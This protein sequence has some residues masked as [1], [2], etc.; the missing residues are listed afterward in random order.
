MVWVVWI[1]GLLV[2]FI[3]GFVK[4]YNK[5]IIEIGIF[6]KLKTKDGS[7]NAHAPTSTHP[8]LNLY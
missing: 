6:E 3:V 1:N 8:G 2:S 7:K 5:H 4:V